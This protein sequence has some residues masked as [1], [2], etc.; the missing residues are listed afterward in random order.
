MT[1]NSGNFPKSTQGAKP[2]KAPK[3]A[4]K[5]MSNVMKADKSIDAKM[6]PAMMRKD[7]ASDKKMLASKV[8]SKGKKK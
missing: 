3:K 5:T 4:P 8:A 7:I 6:T 1:I 2:M